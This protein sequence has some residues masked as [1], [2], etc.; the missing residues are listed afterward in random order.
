MICRRRWFAIDK[1]GIN[2][3]IVNSV[4]GIIVTWPVRIKML[5]AVLCVKSRKTISATCGRNDNFIL[6]GPGINEVPPR[7]AIIRKDFAVGQPQNN[8]TK[9]RRKVAAGLV[10][11]IKNSIQL[12]STE[13]SHYKLC[14]HLIIRD[15]GAMINAVGIILLLA[16]NS[17]QQAKKREDFLHR[18]N[19]MRPLR[20]T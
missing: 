10:G 12:G 8:R 4:A 19:V 9:K 11:F 1:N 6:T 20:K 2:Y 17:H 5:N 7:R 14:R 16:G 15:N 18:I 13:T 3:S